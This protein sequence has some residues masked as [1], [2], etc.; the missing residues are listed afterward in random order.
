MSDRIY[1]GAL[2]DINKEQYLPIMA[3]QY[4][5]LNGFTVGTGC[6]TKFDD[7]HIISSDA[8]NLYIRDSYTLEL[9]K[10]IPTIKPIYHGTRYPFVINASGDKIYHM[11]RLNEDI[12][13][14][15]YDLIS[16]TWSTHAV[17]F[18]PVSYTAFT[19]MQ[20]LYL[21]DDYIYVYS[22]YFYL[23][24][25]SLTDFSVVAYKPVA[26]DFSQN[27]VTF[28]GTYFYVAVVIDNAS[29]IQKLDKNTFTP[30]A[31]SSLLLKGT[32]SYPAKPKNMYYHNGFVYMVDGTAT[33]A[34]N[35]YKVDAVTLL[36]V[37]AFPN[38]QPTQ[39]V[40]SFYVDE[41]SRLF[42][43][44][45]AYL[46]EYDINTLSVLMHLVLEDNTE[47]QQLFS[48]P[49]GGTLL[50]A[51]SLAATQYERSYTIQSYKKLKESVI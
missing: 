45:G 21:D 26:G 11:H 33:S 8:N 15:I 30:L 48:Y 34:N 19:N 35:I 6:I 38:I 47:H 22:G 17:S 50:Y 12:Y 24:K 13:V 14:C 46:Q 37:A 9:V 49:K 42:G 51:S 27:R 2:L 20:W 32:S 3:E 7:T 44:S 29:Y 36:L 40:Q 25:I 4:N 1:L 28:D 23:T 39:G 18:G 5:K 10:Q 43:V 16:N 41:D 31:T